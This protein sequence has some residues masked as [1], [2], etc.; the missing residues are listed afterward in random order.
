MES[1]CIML[2]YL[3]AIFTDRMRLIS[4]GIITFFF[5][6]ETFWPYFPKVQNRVSHTMHNLGMM[7]AFI[8]LVPPI[9]YLSV[10][11][12]EYVDVRR[13]GVLNLVELPIIIKT[14][15]GIM[16]LDLGDYFYHR[17]AHQWKLLWSYHRVHHSDHGMDVTTG[18]RF[19]PFESV[20]LL[21][22][23]IISSFVFGYGLAAV[24][25]YYLIYIPWVL[26]QHANV[27]FHGLLEKSLG[28]V[29]ATP[30]F[31]RVHHSYPQS[32]TDSNYGDLFS[33]WDRAFG[34][35]QKVNPS[36]LKP[37]LESHLDRRKHSL[38]YMLT[39]PF[40]K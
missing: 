34:T 12:F 20:G 5:F 31:H 7:L 16:L 39:E 11:W 30:D 1:I 18:Y 8:L 36:E 32:Y 27:K 22:A 10:Q 21:I 37:G 19:H 35:Y 38:W 17:A 29:F 33:L 6:L 14:I 4:F 15:L 13:L 40:R 25:L 24:T 2:D 26:M 28:Y 9:N 23:Q 3:T